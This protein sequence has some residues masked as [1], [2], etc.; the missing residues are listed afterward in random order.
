MINEDNMFGYHGILDRKTHF[1]PAVA[2]IDYFWALRISTRKKILEGWIASLEAIL[3]NEE[4]E[5]EVIDGSV[6]MFSN[7][8]IREEKESN[9]IIPFPDITKS[10]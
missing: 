3:E 4:F 6:I 9:N 5:P 10:L 1:V 7:E 2:M 8:D